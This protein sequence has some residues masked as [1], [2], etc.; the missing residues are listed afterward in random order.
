MRQAAGCR[1]DS[2]NDARRRDRGGPRRLL[3]RA[4]VADGAGAGAAAGTGRRRTRRRPGADPRR[5]RRGDDRATARTLGRG[6]LERSAG[7]GRRPARRLLG[8]AD[9]QLRAAGAGLARRLCEGAPARRER[10]QRRRSRASGCSGSFV[11]TASSRSIATRSASR[12]ATSS[13]SSR[14]RACRGR[15]FRVALHGPPA[16]LATPEPVLDATATRDPAG[17]AEEPAG[18]RDRLGSRP[19]RRAPPAGAGIGPPPLRERARTGR[20]RSFASPTRRTTTSR[21][22]RSAAG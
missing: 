2:R 21:I 1:A 18:P 19:S 3:E 11:R 8:R 22:D 15:G 5:P 7:L 13:R 17:G 12:P 4:A 16:D 10:R 6:A 9:A 20:R 14:P